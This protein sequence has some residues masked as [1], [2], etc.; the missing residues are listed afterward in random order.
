MITYKELET[1]Y[2]NTLKCSCSRITIAY[3]IFTS[4]SVRLHEVCSS[5]FVSDHWISILQS[6]MTSYSDEDWRQ[7]AYSEFRLLSNLC[8][9][10][11]K[12][13]DDSIGQ[14]LSKSFIASTMI[15]EIDFDTQMNETFSQFTN[16]IRVNF[17][18]LLDTIELTT[19]V[20]QFLMGVTTNTL[21]TFKANL[22]LKQLFNENNN[23]ISDQV[24]VILFI[25]DNIVDK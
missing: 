15:S 9:L 24:I 1:S 22:I 19:K 2:S 12:T 14:F 11:K 7:Q 18:T 17:N 3:E 13:I 25:L 16:S 4:L 10:A 23:Q 5:D 6:S 20:D 8:Q 21:G